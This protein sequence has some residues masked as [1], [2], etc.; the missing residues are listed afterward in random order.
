ME[1]LTRIS[2]VVSCKRTSNEES[3]IARSSRFTPATTTTITSTN[4]PKRINLATGELASREKN[5]DRRMTAPK[6]ATVAAAITS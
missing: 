6:S 1:A 4:P 5:S 2:A 3:K